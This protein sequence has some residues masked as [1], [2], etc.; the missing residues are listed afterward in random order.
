MWVA[1]LHLHK[2]GGCRLYPARYEF[3]GDV[4]EA[5]LVT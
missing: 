4:P 1:D 2:Q 3:L 5:T